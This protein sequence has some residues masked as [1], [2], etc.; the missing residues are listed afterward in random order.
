MKIRSDSLHQTKKIGEILAQEAL[1]TKSKSAL[2]FALEG[3]LGSGKTSFIQ[4][5]AR[6]LEI[7]EKVLSPTFVLMKRFPVPKNGL[8]SEPKELYH[9]D[10]YRIENEKEILNLGFRK[11][12]SNPENIVVIEWADRIKK[13]LPEDSIKIKFGFVDEKTRKISFFLKG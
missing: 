3:D 1:K 10:C 11:I 7:K 13:I 5:F 2:V 6:G 8:R 9:F 12:I 4:G